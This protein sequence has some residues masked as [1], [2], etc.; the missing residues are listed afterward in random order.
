MVVQF[1]IVVSFWQTN[2]KDSE[3]SGVNTNIYNK[4]YNT[5]KIER[6]K[7]A[8]DIYKSDYDGLMDKKPYTLFIEF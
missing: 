6:I 4:H 2:N 8:Y 1:D 5:D 7:A 3:I